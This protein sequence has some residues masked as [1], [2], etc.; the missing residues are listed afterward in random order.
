MLSIF[1]WLLGKP[2]ITGQDNIPY[3]SPV[4]VMANHASLLDGFLLAAF[5]PRRIT[6][7]ILFRLPVVGAFLRAMGAIPVQNE[8]SELAGMRVA[9]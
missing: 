8:G 1:L 3:T 7:P 6:Q 2:I 4:I 9:L 5:W